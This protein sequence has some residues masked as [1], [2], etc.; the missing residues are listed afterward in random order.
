MLQDAMCKYSNVGEVEAAEQLLRYAVSKHV[1]TREDV[2]VLL[3]SLVGKEKR[4][5]GPPSLARNASG[6]RGER[7]RR[8]LTDFLPE[9]GDSEVPIGDAGKLAHML[10]ELL[11]VLGRSG[12]PVEAGTS[13][14]TCVRAEKQSWG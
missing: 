5:R 8:L 9:S 11:T 10:G 7:V 6:M 4:T 12:C 14:S 3:L 1:A 2:A 13:C